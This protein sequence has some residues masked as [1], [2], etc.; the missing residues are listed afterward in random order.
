MHPV[1]IEPTNDLQ[2]YLAKHCSMAKFTLLPNFS[3]WHKN[4]IIEHLL[5]IEQ[6]IGFQD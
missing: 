5:G 3:V 6:T 4:I 2:N 1:K